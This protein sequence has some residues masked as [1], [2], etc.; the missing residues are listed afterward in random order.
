MITIGP[1]FENLLGESFDQIRSS[2]KGNVAIMLRIPGALQTIGG[3]TVSS[4]RRRM[5]RDQVLWITELAELT[6]E[7]AHDRARIDTRVAPV[8]EALE[9]EPAWCAA[10]E[11]QTK[12]GS[13]GAL[14]GPRTAG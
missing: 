3:L 14:N 11:K 9:D 7:S 4:G 2:A 5:L 8:R 13:A 6:L 12:N 1:T 10:E